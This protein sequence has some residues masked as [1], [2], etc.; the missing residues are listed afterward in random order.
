MT[1]LPHMRVAETIGKTCR[2]LNITENLSR[3]RAKN[4]KFT[5]TKYHYQ[6]VQR[7]DYGIRDKYIRKI[8]RTSREHPIPTRVQ[9]PARNRNT[10]DHQNADAAEDKCSGKEC[11]NRKHVYIEDMAGIK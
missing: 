10:K 4:S 5:F 3:E 9:E 8:H 6:Y 7:R 2:L 11:E 1:Q